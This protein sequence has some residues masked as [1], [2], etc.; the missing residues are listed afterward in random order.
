MIGSK[1][2][3]LCEWRSEMISNKNVII[4][5]AFYECVM[6]C[7]QIFWCQIVV[8]SCPEFIVELGTVGGL[9]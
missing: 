5:N 9:I 4:K 7:E 8:S 6:D 3:V 2:H 1:S